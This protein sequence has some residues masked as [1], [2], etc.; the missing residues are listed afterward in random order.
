MF[1]K[2][3][4]RCRAW[5]MF[6]SLSPATATYAEPT[7]KLLLTWVLEISWAIVRNGVKLWTSLKVGLICLSVSKLRVLHKEN[8]MSY[9]V[10]RRSFMKKTFAASAGAER[11]AAVSV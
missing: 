4:S 2:P 5:A 3:M 1:V 8:T 10:N 9:H 6:L 7:A 11:P